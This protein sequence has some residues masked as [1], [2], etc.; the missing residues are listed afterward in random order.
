MPIFDLFQKRLIAVMALTVALAPVAVLAAGKNSAASA[1]KISPKETIR[2]YRYT[3]KDGVLVTSN[4][5][6]PEYARKGYQ[7]VNLGG[8]VLETIAPEPTAEE[9]AEFEQGE[10]NKVSAA[11]QL[12]DD[13]QLLL[14][15]TTAEEIQ[16]SKKRKLT[17]IEDKVKMLN[18]NVSTIGQQIVFEQQKAANL[19]RNG[20]P[21]PPAQ[22]AKIDSLQNELKVTE[23]QLNDRKKEVAEESQRFDWEIERYNFLVQKHGLTK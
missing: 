8:A 15:Y 20:Q 6:A 13:K 4:S 11:Q 18:A 21:I 5:I 3:N 2:M 17:E 10:K 19:E 7:V 16:D 14:R 9:R 22:L 23:S 1:S 12:E